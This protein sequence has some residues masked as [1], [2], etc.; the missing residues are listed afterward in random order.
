M[1]TM[2]DKDMDPRQFIGPKYRVDRGMI[3]AVTAF[4]GRERAT[5]KS[6]VLSLPAPELGGVMD[7]SVDPRR[8]E[9][10]LVLSI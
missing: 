3:T 6:K 9:L 10:P 2:I 4:E 5:R 8:P 7:Y 1:L